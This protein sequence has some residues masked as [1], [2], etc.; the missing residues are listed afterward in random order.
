MRYLWIKRELADIDDKTAIGIDL[1]AYD[2]K[3]PGKLK[4]NVSNSFSI[5]ATAVNLRI[6]EIGNPLG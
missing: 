3:D 1:Q 6:L 5:P 4:V 2:F